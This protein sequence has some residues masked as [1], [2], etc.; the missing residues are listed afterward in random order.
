[1]L[2][3]LLLHNVQ[4][5][6]SGMYARCSLPA[7]ATKIADQIQDPTSKIIGTGLGVPASFDSVEKC[8]A[9]CDNMS[10]CWG[11]VFASNACVLRGGE[12]V[13]NVRTFFAAPDP[14]VVNVT[15]W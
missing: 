1:M 8:K 2:L 7:L 6:S 11:F 13:R 14:V 15:T 12:D 10:T 4:V 5:M 9:A 3:L